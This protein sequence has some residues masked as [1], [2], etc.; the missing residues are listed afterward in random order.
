LQ[1]ADKKESAE[2]IQDHST[3]ALLNKFLSGEIG[4][5]EPVYDSKTGYRYPM[6]EAIAGDPSKVEQFLNKLYEEKVLERKLSDK[7]IF[8]PKCG[9][10]KV[11]F[12]YCC[13]SCKS[14]NIHK[15]SLIE[16][17]KCGYMD[18]EENFRKGANLVCPKC[19]EELKKIDFDYRKAGMWCA[20]RD[21]KKSFDV[22]VPEHHCMECHA[23]SNFEQ[24]VIKDVYSYTLG[25]HV[26]EKMS[27][28]LFLVAPIREFLVK[29]GMKVESPAF[30]KGKS[31][32]K[33]S[34]DIV[35]Y[36]ADATKKAIVV[37]LAISKEAVV[38]E[39]PVIALFAKIFDVLPDKAFLVAIPKL[40]ENAQKM[41][42]LYNIQAIEARNQAEA[43]TLLKAK[44]EK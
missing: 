28:S 38:S 33:H 27:S 15:S 3:Q 22:P 21:C 35:A 40:S 44:L 37:D 4:T 7:V 43:V 6:V 30:L 12:R 25:E 32:A 17:V 19:G 34:F 41:A 8:C 13:P 18:L 26:K 5:L 16:H 2:V 1:K 9:S 11:S 36:K 20:C 14:F 24:A 29:E 31:G 23:T 39:Q 10:S 42:E